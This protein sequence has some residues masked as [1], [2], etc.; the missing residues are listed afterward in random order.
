M[1]QSF[2]RAFEGSGVQI[3]FVSVEGTVAPENKVLNPTTIAERAVGFWEKR[4]EGE[5]EE[6]LHVKE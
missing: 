6:T 2:A 3:G 1:V 5:K 4:G